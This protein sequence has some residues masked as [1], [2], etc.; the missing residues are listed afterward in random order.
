M[1][2]FQNL[3]SWALSPREAVE[4]QRSLRGKV[5]IE[6]LGREI[7]TIAGADIYFDKFSSTVYAGI[8]VLRL[9]S[10]EVIEEVGVRS[11]AQF[12]YV[13]GLL[14]FRETPPLLE[15]WAKLK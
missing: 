5:R 15:A 7:G 14:S 13:P 9:P 6:P 2:P 1:A 10:L 3:H 12:P 8:V 4:L 11:E